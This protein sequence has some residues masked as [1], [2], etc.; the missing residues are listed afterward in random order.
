[1][2]ATP[3]GLRR[4]IRIHQPTCR[5]TYEF[6][7]IGTPTLQ[8]VLRPIVEKVKPQARANSELPIEEHA[9]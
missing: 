9:S 4:V 1:M 8:D 7:E 2:I 3:V 5:V 6:Q